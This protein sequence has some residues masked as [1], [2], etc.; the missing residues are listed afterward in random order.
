MLAWKSPRNHAWLEPKKTWWSTSSLRAHSTHNWSHSLLSDQPENPIEHLHSQF[1]RRLVQWRSFLVRHS[2][3]WR[4]H[5]DEKEQIEL[6]DFQS[7]NV[8][9]RYYF[10][11]ESDQGVMM[12]TTIPT[13]EV[14]VWVW[15]FVK[16]GAIVISVQIQREPKQLFNSPGTKYWKIQYQ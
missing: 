10:H 16:I 2:K 9:S 11:D 13:K 3:R 1:F 15:A 5:R 12:E 8:F 14:S 6:V 7:G 4:G